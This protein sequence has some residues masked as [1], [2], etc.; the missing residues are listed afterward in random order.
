MSSGVKNVIIDDDTMLDVS[1]ELEEKT[2][3]YVMVNKEVTPMPRPPPS[4]PQRLVKKIEDDKYRGFYKDV[5][6][7]FYQLSFARSSL[8]NSSLCQVH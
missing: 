1:G 2:V 6:K 8:T 3:K 5:E 7:T 4:F